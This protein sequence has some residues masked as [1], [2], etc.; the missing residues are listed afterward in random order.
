MRYYAPE[1][2]CFDLRRDITFRYFS[3]LLLRAIR[4]DDKRAMLMLA[5]PMPPD[6]PILPRHAML[7]HVAAIAYDDAVDTPAMIRLMPLP[8]CRRAA[9]CRCHD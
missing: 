3:L 4:F 9:P 2:C 8:L 6:T 1:G 5:T 7:R